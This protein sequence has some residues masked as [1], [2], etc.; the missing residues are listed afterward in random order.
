MEKIIIAAT[1]QNGVVGNLGK[2]PWHSSEEFKHFKQTT[3]S[4]PII[5]G[6]KTFESIGKPLKGRLN[7]VISRN[8]E[9]NYEFDNLKIFKSLEESIIF[10]ETE[11]Y[12]KAFIIGGGE[13]YKKSI[14]FADK[15]IISKM[16]LNAEGDT[17]F[18]EIDNNIWK[19]ENKKEFDEF[20]VYYYSRI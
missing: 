20:I 5:M 3:M 1:A 18:P 14:L 8:P 15:M 6:R 7:V 2:I 13:I 9:L 11:N 16:K 19:V 17:Y 4:F 10:C 12:E